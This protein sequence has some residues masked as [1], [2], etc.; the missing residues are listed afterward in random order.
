MPLFKLKDAWCFLKMASM[1]QMHLR[2]G[3]ASR[4]PSPA[5][6]SNVGKKVTFEDKARKDLMAAYKTATA[7]ET[8]DSDIHEFSAALMEIIHPSVAVLVSLIRQTGRN[9]NALRRNHESLHKTRNSIYYR[10]WWKPRRKSRETRPRTWKGP[11]KCFGCSTRKWRCVTR[12]FGDWPSMRPRFNRS[13]AATCLRRA[14]A[15]YRA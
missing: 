10:N 13:R 1:A 3:L 5:L 14:P 8:P 9:A 12:R 11:C 15:W 2:A 7:H 6:K 4:S